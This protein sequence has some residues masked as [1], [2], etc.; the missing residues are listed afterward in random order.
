MHQ[1]LN[2]LLN[3]DSSF[4]L[5][6]TKPPEVTILNQTNNIF[7]KMSD[8]ML[9][10]WNFSVSIRWTLDWSSLFFNDWY[11]NLYVNRIHRLCLF[12][13]IIRQKK[14]PAQIFNHENLE[15]VACMHMPQ[16]HKSW[17]A[18]IHELGKRELIRIH[19]VNLTCACFATLVFCQ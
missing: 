4:F 19:H 18:K 1:I 2:G 14:L 8:H 5:L 13:V 7:I 16:S 15:V 12:P 3:V 6:F 17:K 10:H 9:Y 11:C